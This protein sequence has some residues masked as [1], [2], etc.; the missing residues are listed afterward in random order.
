MPD[1][2]EADEVNMLHNEYT[3]IIK[4]LYDKLASKFNLFIAEVQ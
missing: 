1:K 3:N 2:L 4:A